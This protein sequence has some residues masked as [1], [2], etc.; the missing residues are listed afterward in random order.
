VIGREIGTRK[1]RIKALSFYYFKPVLSI[2]IPI[3][4]THKAHYPRYDEVNGHYIIKEPGYDQDQDSGNQ[5]HYGL[6]IQIDI[7]NPPF[8][9]ASGFFPT[10][11]Q[12]FLSGLFLTAT[13]YLTYYS[14]NS[15][16]AEG[17]LFLILAQLNIFSIFPGNGALQ[18]VIEGTG[19]GNA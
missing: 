11:K 17:C 4:S 1:A 18:L 3:I 16:G 5:G 6:I 9:A 14:G 19:I 2:P 7:H 15:G 13:L 10:N 8:W 12:E